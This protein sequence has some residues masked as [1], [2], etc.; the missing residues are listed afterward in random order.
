MPVELAGITLAHLTSVVTSQQARTARH[1]VPGMSGDLLQT[2]GRPSVDVQLSGI[3]YGSSATDD[4]RRLREAHL[5]V[6]PVDVVVQAVDDSDLTQTLGFSQV[7]IAALEVAQHAA[8]PDQFD[9]T[10]RLVEYVEPPQPTATDVLGSLDTDL[11]SEAGSFVD[12][13]QNALAQVSQLTGLLAAVPNFADPTEK[14]P[15]MLDAFTSL[16]GG[17]VTA[18]S[19]VRDLF[20]AGG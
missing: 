20:G 18:L 10:C 9:F 16:T 11:V 13:A 6:E 4:L 15:S 5:A 3:F 19:G 8:Y 14:L 1:P 17:G 2:L 12:D 7:L